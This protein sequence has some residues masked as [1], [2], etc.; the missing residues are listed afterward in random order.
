[1]RRHIFQVRK[2]KQREETGVSPWLPLLGSVL[3]QGCR[4]CGRGARSRRQSG[5]APVK[6]LHP[7]QGRPTPALASRAPTGL[8]NA[9]LSSK[10]P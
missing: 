9:A 5:E 4:E 1:M 8:P 7:M 6:G 2:L 10:E 3:I